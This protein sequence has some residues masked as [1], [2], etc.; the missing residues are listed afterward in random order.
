MSIHR[1]HFRQNQKY[2]VWGLHC[3]VKTDL[4]KIDLGYNRTFY[5]GVISLFL[6]YY[7]VLGS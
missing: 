5:K 4:S 1:K 7:L 2:Q 3:I 6:I